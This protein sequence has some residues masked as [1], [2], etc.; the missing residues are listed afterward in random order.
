[1]NENLTNGFKYNLESHITNQAK[2]ILTITPKFTE[3]GFQTI[4]INKF[5]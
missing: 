5:L 4:F 3:F 2:S 1:M